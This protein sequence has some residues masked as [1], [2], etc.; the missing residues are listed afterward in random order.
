[1]NKIDNPHLVKLGLVVDDIEATAKHFSRLFGIEMPKIIMPAEEYSP[2]PTGAT[3][4]VFRGEHVPARVKL[5]NLQMGA[6]TVELLEP[7]DDKSPYAEFKQKHGQGVQFITFTVGG[8]EEN[9]SFV[10]N[11]GIPLVHKGEYGSGR[12][13]FMDSVQQLGVMLGLQELGPKK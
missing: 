8:F 5:A 13:C 6:V 1:M 9:I 11:Q 7:V 3:Y 10:E 2:D 12:Y 4:T